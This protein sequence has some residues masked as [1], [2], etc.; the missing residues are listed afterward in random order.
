MRQKKLNYNQF[1]KIFRNP[2]AGILVTAFI[3]SAIHFQFYGFIP[4]FILGILLG[5]IYWYSGSLWPAIVAHFAYDAFA[6]IMIYFNPA[7]AEKD[8]VGI[9]L[10]NQS[11]MAAISAAL[12]IVI[13]IAMKKR[14]TTSYSTVYARDN[15][16]DS[17]PFA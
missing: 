11:V 13:V 17:N 14:S 10:G 8:S 6:V 1:I 9:S 7:L 16:D 3:F 4:R 15:I 2:W 5:L 12:V